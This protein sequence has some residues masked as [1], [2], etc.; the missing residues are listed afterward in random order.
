MKERDTRR[1][2]ER[3]R[4]AERHT[5]IQNERVEKCKNVTFF[6]RPVT[7]HC[8]RIHFLILVTG[9]ISTHHQAKVQKLE[10]E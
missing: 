10:T 9:K 3:R 1:H 8:H 5:H 6:E 2:G 4:Q 7:G